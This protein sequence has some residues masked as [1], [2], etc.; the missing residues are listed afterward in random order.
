VPR[1]RL[2]PY[3]DVLPSVQDNYKEQPLH[4]GGHE[5]TKEER[6]S[7]WKREARIAA[8]SAAEKELEDTEY[9]A[10]RQGHKHVLLGAPFDHLQPASPLQRALVSMDALLTSALEEY[11]RALYTEILPEAVVEAYQLHPPCCVPSWGEPTDEG[12]AALEA[13]KQ[14]LVAHELGL[15]L[16]GEVAAMGQDVTEAWAFAPPPPTPPDSQP[17]PPRRGRSSCR[18]RSGNRGTHARAPYGTPSA[19]RRRQL[20][21]WR[22]Q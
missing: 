17:S 18:A 9:K 16:T 15:D 11:C 14:R 13:D 5:E 22:W 12:V 8:A 21:G 7:R 20:T 6:N 1:L 10:Q 3:P 4:W 19:C 2:R